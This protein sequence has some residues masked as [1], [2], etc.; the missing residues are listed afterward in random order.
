MIFLISQL[1]DCGW[2]PLRGFP[3]ANVTEAKRAAQMM[4]GDSLDNLRVH[5]VA[6]ETLH[7]TLV[8]FAL[9]YYQQTGLEPRFMPSR[10]VVDG[11][12][13]DMDEAAALVLR[14]FGIFS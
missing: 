6:T 11:L 8:R 14:E 10:L 5:G 13:D 9:R 3:A 1:T 2:Q 12:A 7:S 4:T